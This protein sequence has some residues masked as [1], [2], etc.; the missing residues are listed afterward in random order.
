MSQ[1]YHKYVFSPEDRAFRGDFEGMYRSEEV[2]Q[3][4]SWGQDDLA[5]IV[6]QMSLAIL[7]RYNFGRVLDI[8][9]GKGSFTHLLK[10][11]NNYVRGLDISE[12]A[13]Q[14]ASTRHPSI[15][16]AQA[17]LNRIESLGP[18]R[19][20]LTV[21]MAVLYYVERWRNVLDAIADASEYL[22]VTLY[23][24]PNT[25]GFVPSIE[26][27]LE[28]AARRFIPEAEVVFNRHTLLFLA[29]SKRASP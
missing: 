16:F 24:P 6:P 27:F 10:K 4:D 12:T 17:D 3:F 22:Y 11:Q 21:A 15:D 25:T 29:R 14:K 20:D 23:V 18:E 19:F 5:R 13:I 8:G 26:G 7:G 1:R 28:E 2:E 9:C